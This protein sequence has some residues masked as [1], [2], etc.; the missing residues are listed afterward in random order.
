MPIRVLLKKFIYINSVLIILYAIYILILIFIIHMSEYAGNFLI[1]NSLV[2]GI[3]LIITALVYN[4]LYLYNTYFIYKS[5]ALGMLKLKNSFYIYIVYFV[6][7]STYTFP[8]SVAWLVQ[9]IYRHV[10]LHLLIIIVSS[11]YITSN[12]LKK[13]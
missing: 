11:Y 13:K 2:Q 8:I 5:K 1:R 9:P 3:P 7:F 12:L 6:F 10:Y 4:I